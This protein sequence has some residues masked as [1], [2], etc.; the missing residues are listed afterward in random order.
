MECRSHSLS[1][2][3]QWPLITWNYAYCVTARTRRWYG[4]TIIKLENIIDV[5]ITPWHHYVRLHG[6]HGKKNRKTTADTAALS[7]FYLP[8]LF[9]SASEMKRREVNGFYGYVIAWLRTPIP[10]G[11]LKCIGLFVSVTMH[12]ASLMHRL[13]QAMFSHLVCRKA[14]CHSTVRQ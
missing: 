12:D 6:R 9:S 2:S 3:Q 14:A 4:S 8:L 11:N 1:R 10:E 7:S 13:E 5:V